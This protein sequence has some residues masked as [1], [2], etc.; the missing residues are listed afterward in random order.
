MEDSSNN[1]IISPIGI[2][3]HGITKKPC[4]L[5]GF[6]PHETLGSGGFGTVLRA[7]YVGHDYNNRKRKRSNIYAVK[8][9]SSPKNNYHKR[10]LLTELHIGLKYIH[11]N[12][13][14]LYGLLPNTLGEIQMV[15]EYIETD[16]KQIINSETLITDNHCRWIMCDICYGAQFLHINGVIHRDLKPANILIVAEPHLVA[17]ICD[18]GLSCK[19]KND[20][21]RMESP[22]SVSTMEHTTSS[23][24]NAQ[25]THHMQTR[26]WR[27]PEIILG[28]PYDYAIDIWS[29]GCIFAEMFLRKPLFPGKT[30]KPLSPYQQK[31]NEKG[32]DQLVLILR[33]LC[34]V[35][36]D[37]SWITTHLGRVFV[38]NEIRKMEPTNFIDNLKEKLPDVE[39][40]VIDLIAK[41]LTFNPADRIVINDILKHKVFHEIIDNSNCATT[42][43]ISTKLSHSACD[44]DKQISETI[45]QNPFSMEV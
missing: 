30:C 19:V 16:L 5:R 25:L 22:V 37:M 32:E 36:E 35:S 13:T 12:I 9:M 17:K 2:G 7:S 4:R 15:M 14:R 31:A 11:P 29:L 44:L 10:R 38:N 21:E 1:L 39:A 45:E 8:I 24:N 6:M 34:P 23:T 20:I 18:F 3:P 41:C 26:W 33:L 27:S 42:R 40:D 28:V 43:V